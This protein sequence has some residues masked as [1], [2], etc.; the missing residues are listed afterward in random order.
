MS[1]I[2]NKKLPTPP[3][4]PEPSEGEVTLPDRPT[5]VHNTEPT[6]CIPHV[7][8][9]ADGLR[10]ATPPPWRLQEP[11]IIHISSASSNTIHD[12]ME[13]RSRPLS[14]LFGRPGDADNSY[15]DDIIPSSSSESTKSI[16]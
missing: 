8:Q 10:S 9:T 16:Q 2:R 4:S 6:G 1:Y 7:V 12:A 15:L 11:G 13:H 5:V 14:L 3:Y